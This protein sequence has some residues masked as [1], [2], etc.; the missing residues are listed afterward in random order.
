MSDKE[1][2]DKVRQGVMFWVNLLEDNIGDRRYKNNLDYILDSTL[3]SKYTCLGHKLVMTYGGPNIYIDTGCA[4]VKGYWDGEEIEISY[5][6]KIGL[7]KY[8]DELYMWQRGRN[9]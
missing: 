6:D 7:E 9:E 3:K 4:R 2:Q 8:L 1:I 5:D